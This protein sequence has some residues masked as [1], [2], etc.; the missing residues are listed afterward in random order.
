MLRHSSAVTP[1]I[2]G[3]PPAVT[4]P[5]V[6]D[7]PKITEREIA[8]VV[9]LMQRGV[10]SIYDRSGVIAELENAFAAYHGVHYALTHNSGTSALHAAFFAV[11]VGPGDEVVAPTY[12]FLSTVVPI[13]QCNGTP[14]LCDIDS[15][16]L[17]VDPDSLRRAITPRTRA[18]VLTHI[19]GHP[20]DMDPI[21]ATAREY[22]L[23]IIED[24][25]HAHGAM[26][27]GRKVGTIGA[28]GVF[29]LQTHKPL[30]AGEGG[31]L[32]TD[33]QNYYERAIL[34]GHFG[35]RAL[36]C[37][38]LPHNRRFAETGFGHKYRM[39]PLAAAI[40]NVQFPHLDEWN[41]GRR[42]NMDYLTEQL[43]D[44]PGVTPPTTRPYATRRGYYTYKPSYNREAAGGLALDDFIEALRAEGVPAKRPDSRP[45]H[46]LPLFQE[47]PDRLHH[48]S[49]PQRCPYVAREV[50]Y[51]PGDLPVAEAAFERLLSL[52][53]FTDDAKV[54]L[55]QS[56]GAF[57]KIA[58]NYEQLRVWF[59]ARERERP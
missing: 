10:L 24:C 57:K 11:G 46:L 12:T 19:W 50:V 59:R 33:D 42:R 43:R 15:V 16:T 9:D 54:T 58:A 39:H 27:K 51:R 18:I 28:I 44:V 29:S 13:L 35:D 55:D 1:A 56:A 22:G 6:P 52:P 36:Q 26:Y 2:L 8:V 23:P 3:G 25:S 49:C 4:R 32:I 34:L 30:V 14:V 41:E 48:H 47:G 5:Y 7:W 53:T 21:C 45:L 40:A 31:M 20:A 17:T 37:V 38:M